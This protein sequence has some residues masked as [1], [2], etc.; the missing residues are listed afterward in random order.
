MDH[1][2][3]VSDGAASQYKN[4][5]NFLDLCKHEEDFGIT[6]DWTFMATAH[7]KGPYD[8]IGGVIKR[9]TAK[10]SLMRP[11]EQQIIHPHQVYQFCQEH[12]S[13]VTVLWC[14]EQEINRVYV[15]KLEERYSKAKTVPGTL[16]YHFFSP[17]AGSTKV[18]ARCLSGDI[19][20]K[21]HNTCSQ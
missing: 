7:G 3:Y 12:I 8:G 6:A 4:C 13:G 2:H 5:K 17:V 1:I 10:A 21:T 14:S 15:E 20:F 18:N 16:G 19:D 11:Y 9:T